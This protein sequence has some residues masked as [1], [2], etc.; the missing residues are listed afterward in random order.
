MNT[1][2]EGN[3]AHILWGFMHFIKFCC[4]PKA[5]SRGTIQDLNISH[6]TKCG[7]NITIHSH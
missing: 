7:T 2:F 6:G 5:L 3:R 1:I 4:V